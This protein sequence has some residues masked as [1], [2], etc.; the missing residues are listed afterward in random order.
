LVINCGSSSVKYQVIETDTRDKIA[1]GVV[2]RIGAVTSIVKHQ[3]G[4]QKPVKKTLPI[5]THT[6]ALKEIM[7]FLL[8]PGLGL[9]KSPGDIVAVG[10][11]VVHG[12]ETFKDSVLIDD[13]VI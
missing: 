1:E 8:D 4:A 13:S 5:E 7:D 3:V 2:E 12:G 9:I 10:H 6:S 11:R